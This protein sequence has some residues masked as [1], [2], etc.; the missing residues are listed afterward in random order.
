MHGVVILPRRRAR[1]SRF[2]PNSASKFAYSMNDYCKYIICDRRGSGRGSGEPSG[3]SFS[4]SKQCCS[5]VRQ[6]N[7]R[8]PLLLS[9]SVSAS[10]STSVSDPA[11]APPP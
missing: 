4:V 6:K 3:A 2:V 9:T 1:V 10:A 5:L 7:H 8:D 11:A